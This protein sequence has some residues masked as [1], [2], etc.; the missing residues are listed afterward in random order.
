MQGYINIIKEEVYIIAVM[1]IFVF[2][3]YSIS[4]EK[5][6]YKKVFSSIIIVFLSVVVVEIAGS[7]IELLIGDVNGVFLIYKLINWII[8]N[9]LHIWLSLYICKTMMYSENKISEV[10][11]KQNIISN[12]VLLALVL[13]GICFVIANYFYYKNQHDIWVRKMNSG[14]YDWMLTPFLN[15]PSYTRSV[16]YVCIRFIKYLIV[17]NIPFFCILG[18][19]DNK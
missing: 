15:V 13:V 2:V 5:I 19:K 10:W 17:G 6:N 12:I 9:S 7:F 3:L 1:L 11:K 8:I 14:N 4:K 18:E 16:F